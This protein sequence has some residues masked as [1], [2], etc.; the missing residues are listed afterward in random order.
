MTLSALAP[1]LG[2]VPI[3]PWQIGTG[4]IVCD[5]PLHGVLKTQELRSCAVSTQGLCPML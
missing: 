4:E 2:N 5:E 1:R 3:G